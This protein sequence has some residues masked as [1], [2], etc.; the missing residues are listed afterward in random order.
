MARVDP[1]WSGNQ[2]A[3]WFGVSGNAVSKALK[4]ERLVKSIVVVDTPRGREKKIIDPEL[5]AEEWKANT[6][7][8]EGPAF[9]RMR[10]TPVS[11]APVTERAHEGMT[12]NEASASEKVWKAKIAE[13]K[14]K[15]EAGDLV[16]AAEVSAKLVTVFSECKTALLGI[17]SRARQ[18]LPHL[19]VADI[20]TIEGLIREALEALGE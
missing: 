3:K 18:A 4:S 5:A 10:E 15:Q 11:A 2:F 7:V 6:D 8:T 17:P 19:T 1:P 12:L 16:P 13:L 14:F 20:G 9:L